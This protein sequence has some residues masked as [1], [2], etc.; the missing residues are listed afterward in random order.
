M[1]QLSEAQWERV[2]ARLRAEYGDAAFHYGEISAA[3]LAEGLGPRYFMGS[4]EYLDDIERP[5]GAGETLPWSLFSI[6]LESIVMTFF[7]PIDPESWGQT[8]AG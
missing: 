5:D 3:A 7:E 4:R 1:D 2:R 8:P 6:G